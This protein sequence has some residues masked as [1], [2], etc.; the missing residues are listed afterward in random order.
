M[1]DAVHAGDDVGKIW[2][3]FLDFLE[4]IMFLFSGVFATGP[5]S[6]LIQ[7]TFEQSYIPYVLSFSMCLGPVAN[8]NPNCKKPKRKAS[9]NAA[10]VKK[11]SLLFAVF[12][13]IFHVFL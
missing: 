12:L 6:N 5:G 9:D 2:S 4:I 10:N 13:S 7:G 11:I 8:Q 3:L 1:G